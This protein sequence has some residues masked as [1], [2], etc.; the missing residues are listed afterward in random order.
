MAHHKPP[1]S[2]PQSH[3]S[4]LLLRTKQKEYMHLD[5]PQIPQILQS[6][7]ADVTAIILALLLWLLSNKLLFSYVYSDVCVYLCLDSLAMSN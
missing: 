1:V 2:C 6:Y 5:F 7:H 4:P 3:L